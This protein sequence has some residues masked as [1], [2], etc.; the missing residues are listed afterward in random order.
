MSALQASVDPP[1]AAI[2]GRPAVPPIPA[3]G[4]LFG[5]DYLT[6]C[7]ECRALDGPA[8]YLVKVFE[9][10]GT[11]CTPNAAGVMPLD[12]LI[13]NKDKELAGVRPDLAHIKLSC[14]NTQTTLPAID[15]V[16]E[17]LENCLVF[18]ASLATPPATP[19]PSLTADELA[20]APERVLAKAYEILGQ[21][22]FPIGLPFDLQAAEARAYLEDAG[23]SRQEVIALFRP[24]DAT[25][26]GRAPWADRP[27]PRH[28]RRGCRAGQAVADA[29]RP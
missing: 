26:G 10:L 6:G 16:N 7:E 2:G 24:G 27:R 11:R 13:G 29:V 4:T 12:V 15:L 20:A 9:F 28:P 17:V 14:E 19:S 22:V 1:V 5:T 23:T 3:W 21:Q 18:G 25:A 8:A